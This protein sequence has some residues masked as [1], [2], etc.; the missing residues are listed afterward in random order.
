MATKPKPMPGNMAD[1]MYMMSNGADKWAEY[2]MDKYGL[3]L[4]DYDRSIY[5]TMFDYDLEEGV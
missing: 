1:F 3:T 2:I 5:L 4:E